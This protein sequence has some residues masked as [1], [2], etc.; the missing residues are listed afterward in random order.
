M[1]SGCAPIHP[2]KLIRC[3][4]RYGWA[5]M[6]PS[7]DLRCFKYR[8]TGAPATVPFGGHWRDKVPN[9]VLRRVASVM[10]IAISQ[11]IVNVR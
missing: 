4:L 5:E 9:V 7:G 10:G 1:A 3:W 11:L 6:K 8:A 2:R